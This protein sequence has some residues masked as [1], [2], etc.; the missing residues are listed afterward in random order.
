MEKESGV[1]ILSH[2]GYWQ[3][4]DE[5][6]TSKAF[7]RSLGLGFGTETDFRDLDGQLVISHDPPR[8][9]A[10]PA[11]SFFQLYRQSN[12]DLPLALNIKADGLHALLKT[13]LERFQIQN[14]FVFD[15][16][17]PDGLLY[18]NQGF[19]IFTRQSE[20]EPQPAFYDEAI[21]VWIDCFM[22]EWVT[23][24][25]LKAHLAANKQVCLVSPELHKRAHEPFWQRLA[26]ME[27]AAHPDL[28][29][30]TDYPEKAR[31]W[32]E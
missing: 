21:G 14:Y 22:G 15:Y 12:Q 25:I 4:P 29:L 28:M 32:F 1:K 18:I 7:A 23:E 3:E 16:A 19:R 26:R 20:F 9:G 27:V 6:N 8:T 13:A 24:E 30:C 10:L 31:A 5:K 2:R 17:I 11:Q